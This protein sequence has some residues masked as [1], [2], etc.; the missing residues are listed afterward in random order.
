MK[1][2]KKTLL[3]LVALLAVTTGAWAEEKMVTINSSTL[4]SGAVTAT[5]FRTILENIYVGPDPATI[6]T[7]EGVITK[8]VIK[9]GSVYANNFTEDNV[10]VTPGTITY[11]SDEITV[12]DINAESVTLSRKGSKNWSPS[13]VDVYYAAPSSGP[14]VAWDKAKNSGSFTMPGGNVTLE[15]EYYPQAALAAAP[16][17]INDVPATT[18]GAIV[19][20]GTVKNIGETTTAQGT[21]M[22][23]V[24]PTALDD[25]ALQALAA[26]QWT[27][28]VPTAADLAQGQAYVYY[29]VR[30]NDGDTDDEIFSDGDILAANA[31]TVTIAAAP[32]WNAEFDLT[33]A[34][35]E[36]KAGKWSTDIP[37]GGVVKGTEVKVTY[38]G[39]KKVIGVKA[40]KKAAGVKVT[41]ITLNKTA[42]TIKVGATE[43][44]SVTAVAPD[45][46]TDKTYTW[47]T[48][49]ESKATVD[50]DGKV[51][52]VAAGTVTIYAEAND[53]S[54]VKGNCTVTVTPA[55]ITVTWNNNDITGTYGNSFTK[56]GV[57]ITAGLIDFEEKNFMD[58]GTFT[59]TLGNF[60]K[61][62]VT[63]GDVE[64]LS[65]TG[66]SGSDTKKTWTGNASSVSFNGEIMGMDMGNTKFVFTIEPT[67]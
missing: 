31:L 63:A 39:T 33:N 50:Q 23:Y 65:G 1:Q 6:T 46:A 40:E 42:T 27:A 34:P 28:D 37:E 25:A 18:D 60:T 26:D 4:S 59:T 2:L 53:G 67:N 14:E 30:G 52:A 36:D 8:L 64:Y 54:G 41:A 43:T 32:L 24:S 58:G 9:K 44:L 57:T 7:S 12:T 35:E 10:G 45:N 21:V 62:E 55:T 13:S 47:K 5:G 48:S 51:T 22:Y 29:Y 15:P 66:W 20:A 19:E 38:T 17:A 3:T 16:T 56:D 49:D 11:G 61:I